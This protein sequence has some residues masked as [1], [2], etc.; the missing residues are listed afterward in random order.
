V[1]NLAD[2]WLRRHRLTVEEFHRMGEAG[3]LRPDAR[4]ELIEG[5]IIDMPPIGSRHASTVTRLMHLFV[6]ACAGSA[7]V[8]VQNPLILDDHS[9]PEPDLILLRPRD[10]FYRHA[11][12]RSGDALLVVE[13]SDTSLRFDRDVKLPLYARSNIV[14]TWIVDLE[15]QTLMVCRGLSN[16]SYSD[17]C[18]SA[19]PGKIAP[20]SLPGCVVD[21]SGLF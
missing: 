4:V 12:P 11:L 2:N 14:E 8:W 15:N 20:L 5:E 1:T 3:I 19:S 16:D 7:Q 13:V 18:S 9:E 21:L 6:A 10:D 17:V